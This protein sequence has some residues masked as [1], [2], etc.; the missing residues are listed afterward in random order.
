MGFEIP[1]DV[2]FP[3]HPKS[4]QLIGILGDRADVYPLRLWMWC[5]KFAKNGIIKGGADQVEMACAWKGKPGKL[6]AALIESGFI[7]HD[8]FTVHDWQEHAG[9]KLEQYEKKKRNQ[10]EKDRLKKEAE[11]AADSGG[12]STQSS[13]SLPA[14]FRQSSGTVGGS[15]PTANET[16]RNETKPHE[17]KPNETPPAASSEILSISMLA[18]KA[19]FKQGKGTSP[20]RM[21][22]WHTH[23][24]DLT[25]MGFSLTAIDAEIDRKGR[26]NAEPPWDFSKRL[27]AQTTTKTPEQEREARLAADRESLR[28]KLRETEAKVG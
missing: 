9:R 27:T 6:H 4:I 15:L 24:S 22:D 5:A 1:I 11:Y 19:T 17:I 13:G 8:G 18:Q 20:G 26:M 16:K 23:I 7:E 3:N 21:A 10:R 14:E 28:R 12:P 2:D 25:K